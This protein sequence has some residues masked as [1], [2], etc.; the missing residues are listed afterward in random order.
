MR[1]PPFFLW[2]QLHEKE[3]SQAQNG[4]IHKL[5]QESVLGRAKA[6]GLA[7]RKWVHISF[8]IDPLTIGQP[9]ELSRWPKTAS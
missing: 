5:T 1:Y 2:L 3:K 7:Y 4:C 9:R 6:P 8:N